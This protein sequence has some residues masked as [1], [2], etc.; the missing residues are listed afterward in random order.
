MFERET[1]REKI[2]EGKRREMKLKQKQAASVGKGG[3]G[4]GGGGGGGGDD[5]GESEEDL[6]KRAEDDFWAAIAQVTVSVCV[7]MGEC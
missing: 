4:G 7:C 1:R 6:L 5:E 2:L 3:E